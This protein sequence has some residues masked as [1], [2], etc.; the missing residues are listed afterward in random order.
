MKF[1]TSFLVLVALNVSIAVSAAVKTK[2]SGHQ[3]FQLDITWETK[4]PDGFSRPQILING[5][6]P[7]PLIHVTQGDS[8]EV[9]ENDTLASFYSQCNIASRW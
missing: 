9:S 7:G 8:V 1:L 3:R 2:R 5:Q 6:S 4:A